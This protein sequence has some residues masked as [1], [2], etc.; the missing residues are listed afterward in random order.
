MACR[1]LGEAKLGA[2]GAS[3]TSGCASWR[4]R[5]TWLVHVAIA[6]QIC[7]IRDLRLNIVELQS[8]I[9]F[10]DASWQMSAHHGTRRFSCNGSAGPDTLSTMATSRGG[11]GASFIARR[12]QYR[13]GC[14]ILSAERNSYRIVP[15][16]LFV[17]DRKCGWKIYIVEVPFIRQLPASRAS[18]RCT[19]R[20]AATALFDSS[21]FLFLQAA[22]TSRKGTPRS[23][24]RHGSQITMEE[25]LR[26]SV[27]SASTQSAARVAQNRDAQTNRGH[28]E[29]GLRGAA[30]PSRPRRRIQLLWLETHEH[31]PARRWRPR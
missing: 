21:F 1:V 2:L 20:N 3:T 5:G 27:R 31:L 16:V 15:R 11:L 9:G 29:Q 25:S 19:L 24:A 13:E 17:D 10:M 22:I 30:S 7:T 4:H 6:P 28:P 12:Q 18:S 26:R 23:V 14:A 8:T